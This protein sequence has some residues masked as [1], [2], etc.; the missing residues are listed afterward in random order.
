VSRDVPE[1]P[2]TA[3]DRRQLHPLNLRE[4]RALGSRATHENTLVM[5]R[6]L[7]GGED[8][9]DEVPTVM[10][11]PYGVPVACPIGRST[12]GTHGHLRTARC[13]RSPADRQADPLRKQAF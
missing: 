12:P 2:A 9:G 10:C 6:S 13:T 4:T 3:N 11:D 8:Q 7:D 5:R 1:L